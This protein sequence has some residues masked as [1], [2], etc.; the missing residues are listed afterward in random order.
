[1]HPKQ[2]QNYWSIK[3]DDRLMQWPSFFL[4]FDARTGE[5][6]FSKEHFLTLRLL[7]EVRLRNIH[8]K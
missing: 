1:M 5:S 4:V 8:K 3:A 7:S 6:I 2:P